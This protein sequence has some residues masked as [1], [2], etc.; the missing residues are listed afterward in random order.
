MERALRA[1]L[2]IA[3]QLN[4]ALYRNNRL[5]M[6]RIS[7]VIGG[8]LVGLSLLAICQTAREIALWNSGQRRYTE[9]DVPER[10]FVFGKHRVSI[11]DNLP[12]DT[13]HSQEAVPGSLHL[14]VD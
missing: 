5:R 1:L 11:T 9:R 14:I 6:P 12:T 3:L 7:Q 10:E 2:L 8:V 13:V 4:L